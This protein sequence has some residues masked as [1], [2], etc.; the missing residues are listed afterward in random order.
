[1][2]AKGV[3]VSRGAERGEE[4]GGRVD[5]MISGTDIKVLL[6]FNLEFFNFF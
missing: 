3:R 1:M 4:R 6:H 5:H 2:R